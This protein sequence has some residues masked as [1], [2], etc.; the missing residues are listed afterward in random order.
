MARSRK[1]FAVHPDE[2]LKTEFME[3]MG[4]S[5]Y[6]LA[7]ALDFP[8]IYE[9]VRGDRAISA[10]TAI[11]L[12]KYFGLPAQFWLN[13]QNDYDLRIAEARGVGR[14]IKPHKVTHAAIAV[15]GAS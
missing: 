13:L 14:R 3:P 8:G 7:K 11:R 12:G 4:V 5:A 1:I 10:D 9:V 6:A 15:R 2:I